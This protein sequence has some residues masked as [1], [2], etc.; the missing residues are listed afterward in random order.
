[1]MVGHLARDGPAI[2]TSEILQFIGKNYQWRPTGKLVLK[3]K[4]TGVNP[5][6]D[7]FVQNSGTKTIFKAEQH[8]PFKRCAGPDVPDCRYNPAICHPQ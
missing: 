4:R 1:M 8:P 3:S 7:V 6:A 2:F 5:I